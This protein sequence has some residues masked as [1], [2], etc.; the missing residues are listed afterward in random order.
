MERRL[1]RLRAI[2]AER[3]GSAVWVH[4]IVSAEE[5]LRQ[6]RTPNHVL[7]TAESLSKV[8]IASSA[9]WRVGRGPIEGT[10]RRVGIS[11]GQIS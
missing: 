6:R 8:D 9:T 2:R 11:A 4:T 3:P 5:V 1:S 10:S 7:R